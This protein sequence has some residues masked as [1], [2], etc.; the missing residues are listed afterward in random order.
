MRRSIRM[1]ASCWDVFLAELVNC[2]PS[3]QATARAGTRALTRVSMKLMQ[4]NGS[5]SLFIVE[6]HMPKT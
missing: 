2:G 1:R 6:Q 5:G 4:E 3:T